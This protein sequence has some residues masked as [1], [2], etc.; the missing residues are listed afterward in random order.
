MKI[1]SDERASSVMFATLMLIL[2]V[3][4]VGSA[5]AFALSLNEKQYME[6]Q[7]VLEDQKSENL[8][9]IA[10]H[11]EIYPASN[12]TWC[13]FNLTIFNNDI[14]DSRIR[15]VAINDKFMT[16]HL[17]LN[18]TDGYTNLCANGT[19]DIDNDSAKPI[20]IPASSPLKIHFGAY[21]DNNSTLIFPNNEPYFNG[22]INPAFKT[23]LPIKVELLTERINLFTNVFYPP[24]PISKI[25]YNND[26][27]F[28]QYIVLDGSGSAAQNGFITEYKWDVCNCTG[29]IWVNKSLYGMKQQYPF[30]SGSNYVIDLTVKD[31]YGMSADLSSGAGNITI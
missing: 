11:P 15:A 30:Q 23:N 3:I 14:K 12:S 8:K 5:F 2:I 19:P 22:S 31:N 16:C 7:S 28:G 27:T 21:L 24:L 25:N 26:P 20:D 29:G 4:T 13:G 1:F 18:N 10:I 17:Y 9:V 6:R